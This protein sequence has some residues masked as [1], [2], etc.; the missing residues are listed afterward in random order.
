MV[1]KKQ[2][3]IQLIDHLPDDVDVERLMY[4]LYLKSKLDRSEQAVADG[5]V[6][7]HEQVKKEVET[8]AE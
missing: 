2:E 8:W 6:V 7:S 1:I 4:Q 5:R 3:L